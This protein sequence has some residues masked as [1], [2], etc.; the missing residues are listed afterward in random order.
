[1]RPDTPGMTPNGT[2]QESALLLDLGTLHCDS[3]SRF[4]PRSSEVTLSLSTDD[5]ILRLSLVTT[6]AL[7]RSSALNPSN[8][9]AVP[10][11][12]LPINEVDKSLGINMFLMVHGTLP[13]SPG[14][15]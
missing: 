8:Y 10:H 13:G 15:F 1:M 3:R 4:P 7:D 2:F 5:S 11:N 12:H 9:M 14:Y 6:P